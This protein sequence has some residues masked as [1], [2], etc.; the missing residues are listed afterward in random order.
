MKI[1]LNGELKNLGGVVLPDGSIS[2]HTANVLATEKSELDTVKSY[3]LA[4]SLY[5]G[6][7]ID[8][9]KDT[10]EKIRKAIEKTESLMTF[11][12]AQ[13]EMKIDEE[14]KKYDEPDEK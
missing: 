10:L 12:K 6:K 5:A 11:A 2:K 3:I 8:I 1:E 14:L 13:I 4:Q 7:P 9:E